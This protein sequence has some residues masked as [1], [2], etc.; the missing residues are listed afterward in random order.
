MRIKKSK[1]L[2]AVMLLFSLALSLL[3]VSCSSNNSSAKPDTDRAGNPIT[4]PDKIDKIMSF[5]PSTTEELVGLG[6]VSKIIAVDTYA[7]GIPELAAA[8]PQFDMMAPDAEKIVSLKPDVIFVT[9]MAQVNGDDPYKPIE[10][11]GICVIY[12][13]SSSS[14]DGIKED[15]KYIANVMG[16]KSKGDGIVKDMETKIAD[17]K[18]IGDAIPD[19]EKKSVYFEISAAPSMYSFG[20]GVFLNEILEIVGAKNIL[21]DQS[22][23][24]SVTDEQV[25]SKNPDVILTSVNYIDNPT[26]EIK[27]R[28]GWDAVTAVKNNAVYYIDTNASN[29]PSQNI[30]KA[31][32]AIA[33]AVYPDKYK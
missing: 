28:P 25:L 10:D 26:D 30:T 17:I 13:P 20:T 22:S 9:G 14:I 21:A 8:L 23:W 11:A 19:S 3:F 7:T 18:K 33:K 15:I 1:I 29:R 12:I 2:I 4:L 27:A 5:G 6:L 16:A 31:M 24:V 32:D